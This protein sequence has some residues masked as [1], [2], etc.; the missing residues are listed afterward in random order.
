MLASSDASAADR[1]PFSVEGAADGALYGDDNVCRPAPVVRDD[2]FDVL[3]RVLAEVKF[4]GRAVAKHRVDGRRDGGAGRLQGWTG[5]T[6]L[7]PCV[8]G[9][10]VLLRVDVVAAG[11]VGPAC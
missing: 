6:S 9:T 8:A 7:S 4:E 11:I 3:A 1:D 5:R 10:A 2:D